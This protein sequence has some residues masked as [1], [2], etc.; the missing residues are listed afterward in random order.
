MR[1]P[2]VL[3]NVLP[4]A[5]AVVLEQWASRRI[6]AALFGRFLLLRPRQRMRL[7]FTGDAP[8]R[9]DEVRIL[10]SDTQARARRNVIPLRKGS[11][12]TLPSPGRSS[13]KRTFSLTGG[14]NRAKLFRLTG[15][16]GSLEPR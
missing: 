3:Q 8:S 5:R 4:D 13:L 14:E 7:S 15:L 12:H 1:A 9:T 11:G 2:F 16:F 6:I 10:E